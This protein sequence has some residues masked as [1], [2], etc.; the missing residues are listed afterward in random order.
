MSDTNTTEITS[1]MST[2]GTIVTVNNPPKMH[3]P[4]DYKR[5]LAFKREQGR[6]ESHQAP[7]GSFGDHFNHM[8]YVSPSIR[9]R[10]H[11]ETTKAEKRI[12]KDCELLRNGKSIV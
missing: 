11:S 10:H 2:G 9:T 3:R 4:R 8:F 12:T 1:A 7:A 5:A 6:A